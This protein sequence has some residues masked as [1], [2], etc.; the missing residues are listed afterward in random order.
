[1]K[2]GKWDMA[3]CGG[4]GAGAAMEWGKWNMDA[5][6]QRMK[7]GETGDQGWRERRRADGAVAR[8]RSLRPGRSG[9]LVMGAT[10][11][12]TPTPLF[13]KTSWR[14]RRLRRWR[15]V[16]R[17]VFVAKEGTSTLSAVLQ[18]LPLQAVTSEQ[19]IW[20]KGPVAG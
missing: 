13:C 6:G 1:M 16:Q 18:G 3:V 12:G 17:I 11:L 8:V 14:Y 5:E 2:W 19:A 10:W 4:D 7:A 9:G 15:A 20:M